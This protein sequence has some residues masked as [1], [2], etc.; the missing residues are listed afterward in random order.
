MQTKKT[1]KYTSTRK[2]K[3]NMS[4]GDGNEDLYLS[5]K[6]TIDPDKQ[7]KIVGVA[8]TTILAGISAIRN[9]GSDWANMFGQ[10]GFDTGLYMRGRNEA[11]KTIIDKL[12]AKQKLKDPRFDIELKEEQGIQIHFTALILE[13]QGDKK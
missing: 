7:Y 9:I 11:M 10:K 4:G 6:F 3:K 13:E 2:T 5:D 8:H 12:S 1:H